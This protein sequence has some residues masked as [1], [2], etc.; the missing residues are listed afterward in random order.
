MLR[1][2]SHL[3]SALTLQT[4][5]TSVFF[6]REPAEVPLG[7]LLFRGRTR[8]SAAERRAAHRIGE[9]AFE[10]AMSLRA[11]LIRPE[12]RLP[13]LV[14]LAIPDPARAA[15]LT[16]SS[17]GLDPEAPVA[18]LI[19][20][21]ERAGVLLLSMP[22]AGG[23]HDA[24]S[25]WGGNA[26]DVPVIVIFR[27]IPADRLRFSVAHELGHLVLHRAP[28]ANVEREAHAFASHFL[29]PDDAATREFPQPLTLTD[30]V[31]L[32]LRWGVAMQSCRDGRPPIW[33]D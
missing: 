15:A 16:R 25:F 10:V 18:D 19:R 7:S 12:I 22:V 21:L 23:R 20:T 24:S 31:G 11:Q 14:D 26:L 32:K 5:F 2:S 3:I 30:C 13:R 17:L 33:C 8:I 28:T 1:P 29:I 4:G 9:V 6:S 27:G